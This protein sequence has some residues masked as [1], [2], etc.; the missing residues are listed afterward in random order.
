MIEVPC[1]SQHRDVKER[2]WQNKSCGIVCVKMIIDYFHPDN[3]TTLSSL[4]KEGLVIDGFTKEGWSH[5]S[6]V[7]LL[8]NH[9]VMAYSQEFRSHEI[10]LETKEGRKSSYEENFIQKGIEKIKENLDKKLPVIASVSKDFNG[11]KDTHLILLTGYDD[12]YVYFND[13]NSENESEVQTLKK[14]F[15]YF[16]EYFRPMV[17]FTA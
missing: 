5:H 2:F 14:E 13:P 4:I 11:N 12:K 1:Y 6:L 8:R 10:D 15:S 16:L 3:L 9:G 17:I 7:I